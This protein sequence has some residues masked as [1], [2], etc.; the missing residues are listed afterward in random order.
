MQDVCKLGLIC[1]YYSK[2]AD[3]GL[4]T[5]PRRLHRSPQQCRVVTIAEAGRVH[6]HLLKLV[7]GTKLPMYWLVDLLFS[8]E[9]I[10]YNAFGFDWHFWE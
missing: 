4:A 8:L 1:C 6:H 2:E 7:E 3:P 5:D 9:I 10:V